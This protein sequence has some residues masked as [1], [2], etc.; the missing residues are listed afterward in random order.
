VKKKNYTT[1]SQSG[2]PSGMCAM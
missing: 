2:N 1:A